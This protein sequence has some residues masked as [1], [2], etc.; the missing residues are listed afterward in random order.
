MARLQV[1]HA[2]SLP[3]CSAW[4]TRPRA[5]IR[6]YVVPGRLAAAIA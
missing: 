1:A 4:A 5:M 6:A 2:C 3:P